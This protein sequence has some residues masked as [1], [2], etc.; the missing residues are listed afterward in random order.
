MGSTLAKCPVCGSNLGYD[1]ENERLSCPNCHGSFFFDQIKKGFETEPNRDDTGA[2]VKGYHCDNCGAQIV[3]SE[4]T[5]ATEC[6]YCH[7]PV[8]LTDRIE[9]DI[10]DGII[11]FDISKEQA[12]SNFQRFFEKKKFFTYFPKK[13]ESIRFLFELKIY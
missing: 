4:S 10:P 6:Y 9:K 1:A 2:K 3:T 13:I 7:S 11:L 5:I 8:V 12:T